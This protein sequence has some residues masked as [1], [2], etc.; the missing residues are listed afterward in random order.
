MY[1]TLK[2]LIEKLNKVPKHYHVETD[3]QLVTDAWIA[4]KNDKDY[5]PGTIIF[6]CREDE[7]N[8]HEL[9]IYPDKI[10]KRLN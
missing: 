8:S 7:D 5:P 6:E 9:S 1:M 4:G 3:K 2:E 10:S